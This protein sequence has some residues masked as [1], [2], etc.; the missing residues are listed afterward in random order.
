MFDKMNEGVVS[1]DDY[2]PVYYVEVYIAIICLDNDCLARRW[3]T[4]C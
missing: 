2:I 1:V 3:L 4:E